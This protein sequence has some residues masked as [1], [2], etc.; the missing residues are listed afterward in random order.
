MT[1]AM[2]SLSSGKTIHPVGAPLLAVGEG[3]GVGAVALAT[4]PFPISSRRGCARR[5]MGVTTSPPPV[6]GGRRPSLA[7][8]D[9]HQAPTAHRLNS[10]GDD[11]NECSGRGSGAPSPLPVSPTASWVGAKTPDGCV[12]DRRKDGSSQ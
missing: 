9:S 4:A 7:E 12:P 1:A 3:F 11:C 10:R 8:T 6:G 2:H 5:Q